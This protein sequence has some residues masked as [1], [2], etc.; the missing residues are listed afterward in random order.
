M[1]GKR[2][3]DVESYLGYAALQTGIRVGA[4]HG[5]EGGHSRHNQNAPSYD[6][7]LYDADGTTPAAAA[8][9]AIHA[10]IRIHRAKR[11]Y[12]PRRDGRIV[13]TGWRDLGDVLADAG[14]SFEPVEGVRPWWRLRHTLAR[15]LR[16]RT[17]DQRRQTFI[18]HVSGHWV[19]VAGRKF[20]DTKT[21]GKWV[22]TKDAPGRRK[23]VHNVY[24]VTKI[25][26]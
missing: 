13:S 20:L 17:P 9:S 2:S 3:A 11:D 8:V 12:H 15:W 4:A 16:E 7:D 26:D 23:L 25:N 5:I 14:Y 24:R 19:A 6:I 22:W 21:N 1:T 10:S 18:V